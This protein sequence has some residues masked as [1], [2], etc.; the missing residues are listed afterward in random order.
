MIGSRQGWVEAPYV[1]C[2][3]SAADLVE[4]LARHTTERRN[5]VHFVPG[6][7]VRNVS[8]AWLGV[9]FGCCECH[10]H[11]YDPFTQRDFYSL[12]AFFADIQEQ[13]LYS[14]SEL[15]GKWGSSIDL[16]T[17]A[18]DRERERLCGTGHQCREQPC[19]ASI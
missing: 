11:K 4:R 17:P 6:L 14:G 2:P 15:N 7:L 18:Q 10:N 3:A 8:G 9:T 1:A 19:P 12:E 16:P 13:G 5:V